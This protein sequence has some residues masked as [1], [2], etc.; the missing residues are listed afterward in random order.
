M[1][2]VACRGSAAPLW[3]AATLLCLAVVT[4]AEGPASQ[5]AAPPQVSPPQNTTV[6]ATEAEARVICGGCHLFPPPDVLPRANWRDELVRM[7]LIRDN[8]PEPSGPAGTAARMVSLPPDMRRVLQYYLAAAPERLAPPAAWPAADA[9]RFDV[10]A[11]SPPNPP[12][13]PAISHVRIADLDG[14]GRPEIVASDM[15]FGMILRGR[16]ADAAGRLDVV[17]TMPH[18]AHFTPLDFDK[19]G[20]IDLL[21][22]DMGRFLPADH[23]D[24]AVVWLRGNKAGRYAALTLDGWP[25]VADVE[26]GDFNADGKPDLAVAAFGWRKVG[27]MSV[28]ENRTVD[29][30]QPSF[31]EHVIDPRPGGIHALPVDVNGDG[32]LDI[33]GLLAQQFETIVAYI[34][35]GQGFAFDPQVIYTAPHP[36][37]GSSGIQLDDLD[38]DG[39][40]DVLFTHG[41]TFDD[42]IIKPYHGIQWLENRGAFPFVE[43]TLADLPG[44]F[45]ARTGDLDADGDLD[46]VA[47]AF[48]AGDSN[49]DQSNMASLVWLEQV[50]TGEFVRHTLERKPPRHATLDLADMDGDGDLDIVT[51]NFTTETRPIPWVEVWENLAKTGG[52]P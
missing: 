39:D 38:G 43:H 52:G 47:C 34:N 48:M 11:F 50:K 35:T 14:D 44:V 30:S 27:R 46:I 15:R 21:A 41:D 49:L 28:L 16:P 25:R 37:W 17:A 4:A 13:G 9:A 26:A 18:P 20:I 1:S 19:D 32:R 6:A 45:A 33:I 24:G 10:R 12:P 29:Y 23:T 22:G 42:Q 36:N 5:S 40:L 3:A 7:T 31:S 2:V 8:Q 51:G